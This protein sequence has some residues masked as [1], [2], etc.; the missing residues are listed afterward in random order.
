[1]WTKF[2]TWAK[3][4]EGEVQRLA[5]WGYQSKDITAITGVRTRRPEVLS[6]EL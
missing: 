6:K 4:E 5:R 1:M 2:E 3:M